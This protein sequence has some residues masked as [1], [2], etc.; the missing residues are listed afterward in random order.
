MALANIRE[1]LQLHFDA[2]AS[3]A[4]RVT[5]GSYEVTIRLPYIADTRQ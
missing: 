5:G 4:S 3:M 1:R 2:E